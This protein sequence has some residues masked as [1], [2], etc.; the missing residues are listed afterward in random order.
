MI[1]NYIE[2]IYTY[3]YTYTHIKHMECDNQEAKT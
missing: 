1:F 2:N 3:I